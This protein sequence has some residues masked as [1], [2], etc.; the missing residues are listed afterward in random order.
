M[1]PS[2]P[3]S[4]P[5]SASPSSRVFHLARFPPAGGSAAHTH[6]HQA[7]IPSA[8]LTPLPTPP[9][10]ASAPQGDSGGPLVCKASRE[11]LLAGIVSWGEGCAIKNRP[12]VY[13]RLTSYQAWIHSHVPDI[14]FVSAEKAGD[15]PGNAG[16]GW[17][18][19]TGMTTC[20]LLVGL[21]LMEV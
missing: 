2:S 5:F 11:W 10:S 3:V 8:A 13:S 19:R 15:V 21:L 9:V 7:P 18:A 6:S 4:R 17:A 1:G 20:L 12:G 16:A 14:E